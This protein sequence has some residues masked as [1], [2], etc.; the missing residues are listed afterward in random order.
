MYSVSKLDTSENDV[1]YAYEMMNT[2]FVSACRQNKFRNIVASEGFGVGTDTTFRT[3]FI[4]R[5]FKQDIQAG[6]WVNWISE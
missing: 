6:R 4:F 2:V 5:R 1:N 3:F